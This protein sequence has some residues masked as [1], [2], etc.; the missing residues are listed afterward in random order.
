MQLPCKN[1]GQDQQLLDAATSSDDAHHIA[2]APTV[3]GA[4]DGVRF[5]IAGAVKLA[6]QQLNHQR[7]R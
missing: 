3:G 5:I 4:V 6:L 1:T 2:V 7:Q